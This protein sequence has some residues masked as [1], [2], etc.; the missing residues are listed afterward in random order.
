MAEPS[1]V[2]K[3][4]GLLWPGLRNLPSSRRLVGAGDVLSVLFTTPIAAF[5]IIWLIRVTDISIFPEH[6]LFILILG[7]TLAAL[8]RLPYFLIF[9]FDAKPTASSEGSLAGIVGWV[10]VFVLGPSI[11]WMMVLAETIQF[12]LSVSRSL[13]QSQSWSLLRDYSINLAVR[14]TIPLISLTL[15]QQLGGEIPLSDLELSAITPALLALVVNLGGTLFIYTALIAYHSWLLLSSESSEGAR[16]FLGFFALSIAVT[17]VSH[18]F[19]ILGAG[20][21]IIQG[22][23][24]FSL[25]LAGVLLAALVTRRLSLAAES[26][27]QQ[28]H[29][30]S[31]LEH[32]GRTIILAPGRDQDLTEILGDHL[33][34][35]FPSGNLAIWTIPDRLLHKHPETWEPDYALINPWLLQQLQVSRFLAKD[36][37]PWSPGEHNPLI[38]APIL[39]IEQEK[40]YGGIL[41]ELH[42]RAEAWDDRSMHRIAAGVQSLA[43]LISSAMH[44]DRA[45][46]ELQEFQRVSQQLEDAA[47]IQASFL[48]YELPP[49]PGWQLSV[50]LQPAG[51][52]S[53]DFFDVF[54]LE[55]GRIGIIIADVMDKGVGAALYMALSRTLMRVYASETSGDPELVFFATNQ[56]ILADTNAEMFVTAFYGVLDPSTSVLTYCNAGHNPPLLLRVEESMVT[57][58]LIRTGI[59]IG[60]VEGATWT[61][62]SLQMQAGDLLILYTDGIPDAQN[63]ENEL[64]TLTPMID[65]AK[66]KLGQS[67]EEVQA[68]ILETISGFVGDAR[69]F[70]DITL[71]VL[72]QDANDVSS[73]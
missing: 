40:P 12:A 11:L 68:A 35:M 22:W 70:D 48:D 61:S 34:K 50:A 21:F 14:A 7:V 47:R 33:I 72:S 53:G 66:Q 1:R 28:S 25:F 23:T 29:L 71:M 8:W 45:I 13:S 19:S 55:D 42:T 54:R 69:Q 4:A 43:A 16:S 24:G 18:P 57:R 20:L 31:E 56:R 64:L 65:A 62:V 41:L 39:E 30:L 5:G 46:A 9:D 44:Q 67:A 32:L 3:L 26:S 27:R 49:I 37:L 6:W 51:Q 52:T 36:T 17:H 60:I 59:P 2:E 73:S 15:Y 58:E 63:S 38:I 10:A